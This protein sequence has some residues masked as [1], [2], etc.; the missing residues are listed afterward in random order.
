[1]HRSRSHR[2][3]MLLAAALL[4]TG[5]T[6]TGCTAGPAASSSTS[7]K[8]KQQAAE[9]REVPAGEF[10][11]DH[12]L[13]GLEAAEIIDRLDALPVDERP[14]DLIASVQPESLV[15][16]DDQNRQT[17]LPMPDDLMY[18]SVAPYQSQTHDCYFH[19]L[20]TC[21]GELTNAEVRVTLTDADGTV[22]ID[23]SRQTFDNGFVGLWVQ[24]GIEA[25]LTITH[26]GQAAT[27]EVSTTDPDDATC[28]TTM[29][30][31]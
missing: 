27:A 16:T 6:V 13:A 30:L 26:D 25:S 4:A 31:S 14:T 23:E 11:D 15:L 22:L 5:L 7:G 20:T 24:R 8:T 9:P 21:L 12:D 28:I 1:M 18:I 29:R 19:S 10:L 3:W 17:T 2:R